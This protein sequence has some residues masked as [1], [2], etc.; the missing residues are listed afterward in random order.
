MVATGH[1]CIGLF[2]KY[3][4]VWINLANKALKK[5]KMWYWRGRRSQAKARKPHNCF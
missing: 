4:R 2:C 1:K 5:H 3:H